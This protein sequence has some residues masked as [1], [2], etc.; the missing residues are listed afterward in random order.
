MNTKLS[1]ALLSGLSLF[2]SVGAFAVSDDSSD[3]LN[4]SYAM[5]DLA[6]TNDPGKPTHLNEQ[7]S[8]TENRRCTVGCEGREQ[9]ENIEPL[10]LTYEDEAVPVVDRPET[11]SA[12]DRF[13]VPA[14]DLKSERDALAQSRGLPI[15][16]RMPERAPV[17]DTQYV[18]S[19]AKV[20]Y[21]ITRQYPI[22]VQYPV[23]VQRNMTVEQ[24]V[25]MQQ[26]VIVRR[27][28]V[29]QQDITVQ[30]Q[31]TVI[32]HQPVVMQ[33][34]PTFVQQN[35][36]TIQAPAHPIS[37]MMLPS[38]GYMPQPMGQQSLGQFD[39]SQQGGMQ[40]VQP[41]FQQVPQPIMPPAPVSA[42]TQPGQP[43]IPQQMPQQV[44]YLT[45]Q[46]TFQQPQL[47]PMGLASQGMPTQQY[48][49]QGQVMAQPV[50]APQAYA[51]LQQPTE[52]V[53]QQTAQ[54][55]TY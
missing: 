38:F 30:R 6:P 53:M 49:V 52:P 2:L 40:P 48:Y 43:V 7:S 34:Q 10:T 12:R 15:S 32:Q 8:N 44:P 23:T 36:V 24:P 22:S 55:A 19:P 50:Y 39:F 18:Q 41:M 26:P 27:P 25:I 51:P 46:P 5:G 29:M 13:V 35:P 37:S 14:G 21:P 9:T 47:V 42:L 16:Q 4:W 31:P 1:V 33:Q 3:Y 45:V 28:V 17:V 11:F 54:P 20:Q